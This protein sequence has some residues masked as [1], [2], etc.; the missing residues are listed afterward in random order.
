VVP[1]HFLLALPF[2]LLCRRWMDSVAY[3]YVLVIWSITTFISM[4]GDMAIV[5]SSA[6]Y[7]LLAADH[8]PVTRFVVALY[9]WD[10]FI[11]LAIVANILAVIWLAYETFRSRHSSR[12]IHR[13]GGIS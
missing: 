7:P 3:V 13:V 9:A 12:Y 10:R 11:T 8:S 2:V 6:A 4:F 5:M 1:T